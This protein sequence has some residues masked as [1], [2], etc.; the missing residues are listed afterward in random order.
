[1]LGV[2]PAPATIFFKFNLALHQFAILADPIVNPFAS[3]AGES[4]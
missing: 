1:M 2:L 4:D 3:C